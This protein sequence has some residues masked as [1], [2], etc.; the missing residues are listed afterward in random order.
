LTKRPITP[1]SR[2]WTDNQGRKFTG[3]FVRV[4][5]GNVVT[6]RAGGPVTTPFFD[7][8]EAD[9]QYVKDVLTSRGEAALIPDRPP[10]TVAGTGE[11]AGA[12]MGGPAFGPTTVPM[13]GY[14]PP[15]MP[16]DS[17]STTAPM[18]Y[19]PGGYSPSG[20]DYN[21]LT[22]HERRATDAASAAQ[23]QADQTFRAQEEQMNRAMQSSSPLYQPTTQRVPVCSACRATLTDAEATGKRCP[24]CGAWWAYDTYHGS[25]STASSDG[26]ANSSSQLEFLKDPQAKRNFYGGIAVVVALAV[27]LAVVIGVIA[28]ALAIA[29]ASRAGKRYNEVG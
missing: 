1:A 25:G 23:R 5:D 6:T 10:A 19:G 12:P 26:A 3:K 22:D 24:R 7:L 13:P 11:A 14:S 18:G 9:Q 28:V 4:F 8:V 16:A 15:P 29:S 27:V 2:V 17:S 21:R 20:T